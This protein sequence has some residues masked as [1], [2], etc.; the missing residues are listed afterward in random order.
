M[1]HTLIIDTLNLNHIGFDSRE[2][3][4]LT[5]NAY[6]VHQGK[7]NAQTQVQFNKSYD[8]DLH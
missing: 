6:S 2:K 8:Q 1:L 3:N 5:Y 4:I 7:G